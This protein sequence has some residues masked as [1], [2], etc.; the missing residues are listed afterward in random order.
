MF[1]SLGTPEE[2]AG[3][4]SAGMPV[5]HSVD[6]GIYPFKFGKQRQPWKSPTVV[7]VFHSTETVVGIGY[8]P[9]LPWP[10]ELESTAAFS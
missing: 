10:N 1:E 5:A 9:L 4:W 7:P 6:K 3:F 2:K 8:C